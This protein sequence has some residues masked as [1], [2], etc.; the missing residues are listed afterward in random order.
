MSIDNINN[1]PGI[2][3]TLASINDPSLKQTA[4]EAANVALNQAKFYV[5]QQSDIIDKLGPLQRKLD[6]G[7]ITDAERTIYTGYQQQLQQLTTQLNASGKLLAVDVKKLK[8][9]QLQKKL[10]TLK[11]AQGHLIFSKADDL[12]EYILRTQALN[13]YSRERTCD[14]EFLDMLYVV[15]VETKQNIDEIEALQNLIKEVM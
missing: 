3:L 15:A 9:E 8:N 13:P 6:D 11:G 7:T 2:S 12:F 4:I 5:S 14:I 1:I 10:T